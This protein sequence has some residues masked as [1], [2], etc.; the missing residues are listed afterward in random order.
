MLFLPIESLLSEAIRHRPKLLQ[1]AAGHRIVLATPHTLVGLLWSVAAMWRS[2]T[3]AR[4]AEAMREAGQELEKRLGTFLGHLHEVGI[5][6]GKT[7]RAYN[8]AVGSKENRLIPHLRRLRK[9]GGRPEESPNDE[10]PE[11]VDLAPRLPRRQDLVL[12]PEPTLPS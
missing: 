4:N 6:L 8:A 3:G 10:L 12:P 11:P 5:Q 2:E 1:Y 9:L 7:T